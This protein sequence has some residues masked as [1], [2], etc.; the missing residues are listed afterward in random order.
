MARN[1]YRFYL[2]VVFVA[3]LVFAAVGL[4]LFL[5]ALLSLSGLRGTYASVPTSEAI[6]QAAVFFGVSWFIAALIGG[7]HYWLMRRDMYSDPATGGSNAIRSFFLNVTELI[8]APLAIGTGA[9]AISQLGQG[10]DVTANFAIAI[11]LLALVGVLEWERRRSQAGTP[12][13]VF[14]QRLGKYGV[15]FILLIELI[16]NS[17]YALN[18]L[19]DRLFFGGAT[20]NVL[21]CG[22]SLGCQGPNA[23]LNVVAALWVALFWIAYGFA[24]RKETS[25][26]L[27]RIA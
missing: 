24:G 8:A 6:T 22:D 20:Y 13:G 17:T 21:Y 26:L 19:V 23:L 4:V 11:A 18:V 5:Q 2:Y 12:A 27:Q 10:F 3:M 7:L 16:V 25:S 14:F 1:L 9:T 15:Q